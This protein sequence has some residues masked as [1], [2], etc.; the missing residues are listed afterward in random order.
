MSPKRKPSYRQWGLSDWYCEGNK[1]DSWPR[2][3][4]TMVKA[5]SKHISQNAA[6]VI[7]CQPPSHAS[8]RT[9][10]HEPPA[11]INLPTGSS[12][13]QISPFSYSSQLISINHSDHKV[14]HHP[15][16]FFSSLISHHWMSAVPILKFWRSFWGNV[17]DSANRLPHFLWGQVWHWTKAELLHGVHNVKASGEIF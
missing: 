5:N 4:F 17:R 13:T 9:F 8:A 10:A 16:D 11:H 14:P 1:G 15:M 3:C 2:L 12:F 7:T 6:E